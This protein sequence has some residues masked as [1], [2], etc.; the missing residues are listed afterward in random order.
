MIKLGIVGSDNSHADR[1]SEIC[2]LESTKPELRI[3]GARVVAICGKDQEPERTAEV[4]K[5]NNIPL[6]VD[7]PE[8]LIGKIDAALV[9]YRD[10]NLHAPNALPLIKAGIPTFVDKPFS[11]QVGDARRMLS[12]AEKAGA[13]LTSY[14]TLRF[15]PSFQKWLKGLKKLGNVSVGTVSG[16][17][18]PDYPLGGMAFYGVHCVELMQEVFGLGVKKVYTSEVDKDAVVNVAY[19]S[20][21]VVGINL[22]KKPKYIFHI[23]VFGEKGMATHE[24]DASVAYTTG[25]KH[26]LK[27]VRTGKL[28]VEHDQMLE[29]VK[30]IAAMSRSHKSGGAVRIT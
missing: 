12:A 30:V 13:I 22:L 28:P 8:E 24:I 23:A 4:A 7:K 29:V 9:V 17:A 2:N 16:P 10:G 6:I 26:F 3:K 21:S 15:V 20:N 1:F 5:N 19:G 25:L 14:S 18:N 27:V 11:L